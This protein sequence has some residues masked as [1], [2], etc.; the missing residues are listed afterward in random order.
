MILHGIDVCWRDLSTELYIASPD[1]DVFS[2][3]KGVNTRHIDIKKAY[4]AL[5]TNQA[6]SLLGFHVFT[7]CDVTAKFCSKTK[8]SCWKVFLEADNDILDSFS[9]FGT[10]NEDPRDEHVVRGL[11]K[12]VMMLYCPKLPDVNDLSQL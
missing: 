4:D 8:A 5:G 9:A 1:T 3:G 10:I 11:V 6:R 7:G 12:Y 2:T